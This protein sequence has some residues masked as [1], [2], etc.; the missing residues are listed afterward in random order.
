MATHMVTGPLATVK[1]S[2]G[3]LHYYYTGAVLPEGT[4]TEEL[5]RLTARG[6]VSRVADPLT[7]VVAASDFPPPTPA[8]AEQPTASGSTV[9]QTA[10]SEGKT[11]STAGKSTRKL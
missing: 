5:D 2:A 4:S 9:G 6:L 7:A 11:T 10:G 1:D 8:I 3:K